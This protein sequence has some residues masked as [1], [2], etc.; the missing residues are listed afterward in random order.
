MPATVM[1]LQE[2][3]PAIDKRRHADKP[4]L[5]L[6]LRLYFAGKSPEFKPFMDERS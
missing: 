5:R 1:T 3:R 2:Q 6:H 4:Q